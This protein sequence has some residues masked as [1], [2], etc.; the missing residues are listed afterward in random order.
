MY[1]IILLIFVLN[2]RSCV[3]VNSAECQRR[4]ASNVTDC[5]RVLFFSLSFLL[6]G[7]DGTFAARDILMC[8]RANEINDF[9]F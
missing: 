1:Y 6:I 7:C 8:A 2:Q 5:V 9:N 3:F 4:T